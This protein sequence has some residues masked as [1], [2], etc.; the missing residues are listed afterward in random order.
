MFYDYQEIR[1]KGSTIEYAI[2]SYNDDGSYDDC[3][4]VVALNVDESI[5]DYIHKNY[6]STRE[7]AI[8]MEN[9]WIDV[10]GEEMFRNALYWWQLEC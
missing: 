5:D 3:Q 1:S 9:L 4:N 6:G 10:E 8:E 2:H 7:D